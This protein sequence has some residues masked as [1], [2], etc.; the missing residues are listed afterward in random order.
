MAYLVSEDYLPSDREGI[1]IKR[2]AIMLAEEGND[3]PD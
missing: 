1:E 3:V 2:A